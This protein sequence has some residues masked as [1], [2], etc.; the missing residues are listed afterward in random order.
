MQTLTYFRQFLGK[1]LLI[2][3]L[4]LP[5]SPCSAQGMATE[6]NQVE[7]LMSHSQELNDPK[8]LETFLDQF[9]TERMPRLHI[10]G[11][12]FVLV[13]DGKIFSLRA[14]GIPTWKK[15]RL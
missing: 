13:K 3:I 10:P 7:A 9:F 15:R 6:P 14:T 5:G 12:A 4:L 1:I 11:A 2:L 8:E